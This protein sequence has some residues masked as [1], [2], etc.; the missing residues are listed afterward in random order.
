MTIS[1]GSG[2]P[3]WQNP[4]FGAKIRAALWLE[5]QVGV[6]GVFTKAELRQAFP[7]VAQID[8]R[9]RELRDHNWQIDTHREDPALK[10]QEQKYVTRGAEI[11]LPGQ[12]AAAKQKTTLTS[13]QRAKVWSDDSFLCR[14]CGIGVGEKYPDGSSGTSQLAIARRKVL[15]ADG[16]TEEQLVT[17]CGKCV[18]SNSSTVD[19]GALLAEVALLSP[20]EKGALSSWIEAGQRTRGALEK[21][22]GVLQ[23]LPEPSRQAVRAAVR[24]DQ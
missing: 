3:S 14:T 7:D 9:V 2:L 23:T 15:L 20:I 18:A 8:R 17:V 4:K 16:T 6:G 22:W 19:L 11:W 13:T 24:L 1:N 12:A 10:Q 5:T 21:V